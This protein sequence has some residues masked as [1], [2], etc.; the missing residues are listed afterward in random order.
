MLKN[1]LKNTEKSESKQELLKENEELKKIRDA[2]RGRIAELSS[3]KAE[4][5]LKVL[6][7]QGVIETL[8]ESAKTLYSQLENEKGQH[9]ALKKKHN[10]IIKILKEEK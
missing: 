6:D 8:T 7:L 5:E 3:K 2:F 1:I 4:S 10:S 9:E